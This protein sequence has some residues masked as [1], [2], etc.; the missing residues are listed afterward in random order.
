MPKTMPKTK[1]A[2]MSKRTKKTASTTSALPHTRIESDS[3]GEM[4]V[5]HELLHGATTQRAVLNFPVSGRPLPPQVI[6]SYL[7]LK[8]ACA[9]ANLKLGELKRAKQTTL[10]N[11]ANVYWKTLQ[12]AA[13]K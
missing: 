10:L 7:E 12:I 13:H 6:A 8:R 5:H 2:S 11:H 3:M 1:P 9:Q 4:H